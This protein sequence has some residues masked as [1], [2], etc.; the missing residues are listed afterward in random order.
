[1][2]MESGNYTLRTTARDGEQTATTGHLDLPADTYNGMTVTLLKN[3]NPGATLT[4]HMIDFLPKPKIYAVELTPV[5][6]E[7]LR[8]GGVSRDAIHYTLKPQL[9]WFMKTLA[10]VMGKLPAD[11]HFWL[12]KGKVPAFL[13]FEG[14]LSPNGPLWRIDQASP[15]LRK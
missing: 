2:D 11:Y 15:S 6:K 12:V 14:P 9:S 3:I 8:A 5:D 1:M 4:I 10:S 13:R 7:S